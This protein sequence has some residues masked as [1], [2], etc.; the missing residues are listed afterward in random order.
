MPFS[1]STTFKSIVADHGT[2]GQKVAELGFDPRTSGLTNC[3]S[4]ARF[5]FNISVYTH[6]K[7]TVVLTAA[8]LSFEYLI[9]W[10]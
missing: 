3:M 2:E 5:L 4:P 6:G 7:L 8:P 10:D 9:Q 1:A